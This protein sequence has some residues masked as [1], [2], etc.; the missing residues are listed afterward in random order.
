ML[1][2]MNGVKK[3]KRKFQSQLPD[4][5]ARQSALACPAIPR[6]TCHT[7]LLSPKQPVAHDFVER[8]SRQ[9]ESRFRVPTCL[10]IVSAAVA[11][12]LERCREHTGVTQDE[13]TCRHNHDFGGRCIFLRVEPVKSGVSTRTRQM[14]AQKLTLYRWHRTQRAM[15]IAKDLR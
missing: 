12:V 11:E 13:K 10:R 2:V 15:L 8:M 6:A 9:R 1:A 5:R 7:H 3:A 14:K 4:S